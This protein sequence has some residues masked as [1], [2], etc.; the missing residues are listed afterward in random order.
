[1]S[2]DAAGA[3]LPNVDLQVLPLS[4]EENSGLAGSFRL[5]RLRDGTTVGHVEVQHISR[6]IADPKEVQLLNMRYGIIRAQALSPRESMALIEKALGET[7]PSSST[8]ELARTT[9]G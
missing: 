4:H 8:A 3:R 5:L 1:V 2:A 9:C 6:V 7:W